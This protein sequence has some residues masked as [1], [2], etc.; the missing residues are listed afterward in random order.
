MPCG[1]LAIVR[2]KTSSGSGKGVLFG[3]GAYGS[4]VRDSPSH[5]QLAETR[6]CA[7]LPVASMYAQAKEL[8][9]IYQFN[10]PYPVSRC[11]YAPGHNLTPKR[12]AASGLANPKRQCA[13]PL[14]AFLHAVRRAGPL[15]WV[16]DAIFVPMLRSRGNVVTIRYTA[17]ATER[18][19][20][21]PIFDRLQ[22]MSGQPI[23]HKGVRRGLDRR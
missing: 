15:A 19:T 8:I 9:I 22:L 10:K 6:G 12:G 21:T 3:S 14:R 20:P 5:C 11:V 7:T 4:G 23:R 16:Q 18:S 17:A 2:P 1:A 13:L